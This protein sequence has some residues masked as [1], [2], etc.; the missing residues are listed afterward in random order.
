MELLLLP[1]VP[2]LAMPVLVITLIVGLLL[3]GGLWGLWRLIQ[4]VF[5][6]QSEEVKYLLRK[7]EGLGYD[8][9]A[10]PFLKDEIKSRLIALGHRF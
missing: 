9:C 2:F 5:F 8:E 3:S 1:L 10:P 7:L 4:R 6:E